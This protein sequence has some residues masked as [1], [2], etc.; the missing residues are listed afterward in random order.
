[1]LYLI[2]LGL[3]EKG[4]S[5]EALEAGKACQ[6][7]YIEQYTSPGKPISGLERVF[8]KRIR[9]LERSGLEEKSGKIIKEA[10]SLD[11]GVLV[12]GDALFATTHISLILE[13]RKKE[14]PYQ[15]VHGPSIL[16]AAG[17]CGLSLYKFGEIVTVP[18]WKKN[19]RPSGFYGTI[20]RNKKMGL[21]S[22]ILLEID[23]AAE[24]GLEILRRI[25]KGRKKKLFQGKI[26]SV[27]RAGTREQVIMYGTGVSGQPPAV[28]ILPGRLNGFEKE[29]LE[30]L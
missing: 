13:C 6:R 11:V 15:V 23:M 3:S 10:K 4:M 18:R 20:L 9:A 1:M 22:L 7:L 21:H 28:L 25:E 16:A 29:F 17:E 26:V 8:G 12:W 2:S 19:Y 27:S 5:L 30:S 24:E 14:I